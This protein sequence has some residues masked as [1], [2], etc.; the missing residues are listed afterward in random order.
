MANHNLTGEL[1]LREAWDQTQEAIKVTVDSEF[2]VALDSAD[3]DSVTT[4]PNNTNLAGAQTVDASNYKSLVLYT[5]AGAGIAKVEVSPTST[6][7]VF[8]DLVTVTAGASVAKSAVI[9]FRAVRIRISTTGAVPHV[10]MH[11]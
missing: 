1:V 4:V 5:E 3:G 7:E 6:G 2:A 11:G 9:D 10:V 8:V